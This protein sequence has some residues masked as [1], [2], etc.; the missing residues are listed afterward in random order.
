METILD[1][2]GS[3]VIRNILLLICALNIEKI[4]NCVGKYYLRDFRGITVDD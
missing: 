4:R 1:I 3:D 2:L